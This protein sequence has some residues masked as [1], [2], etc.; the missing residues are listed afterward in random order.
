MAQKTIFWDFDG[1]LGYREGGMW[2]ASLFEILQMDAPKYE[3][4]LEQIRPLMQNVYFWDSPETDHSRLDTPEKWWNAMQPR[5]EAILI[6]LGIPQLLSQKLSQRMRVVYPCLTHWRLFDDSLSC[7]TRL[8]EKG[9]RHML[10]SNHVPELRQ[11]VTH[12]GLAPYLAGIINSAETGYEKPN[13]VAFQLALQAANHPDQV[14]M[15]GD[16]PHADIGGAQT[17]GIPAILVRR[18]AEGVRYQCDTLD[19]AADLIQLL[20]A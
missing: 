3:I 16:N 8:E 4:T 12:L 11:I 17:L 10:L 6:N 2:S 1:T 18:N 20:D 19:Q 5:F 9:W 15:V 13:P 7:L 14:W